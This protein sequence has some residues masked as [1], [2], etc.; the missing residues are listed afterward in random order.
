MA[1]VSRRQIIHDQ[2]E[3]LYAF[4]KGRKN[5]GFTRIDIL[6][7]L[8]ELDPSYFR[9]V[10]RR[11][12]ALAK[13]D[14]LFS[15]M[16]VR[17][18]NPDRPGYLTAPIYRVADVPVHGFTASLKLGRQEQGVKALK[19]STDNWMAAGDFEG[20]S[21][22]QKAVIKAQ[23]KHSEAQRLQAEANDEMARA[24]MAQTAEHR[25]ALR[26]MTDGNA[27]KK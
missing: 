8:P 12:R 15:P 27:D 3:I 22:S 20:M 5:E 19:E 13:D 2:A 14:G 9:A 11:M 21:P 17:E 23:I 26:K 4:L 24:Y 1:K 18:D 6:R 10:V 25:A 7:E 16:A